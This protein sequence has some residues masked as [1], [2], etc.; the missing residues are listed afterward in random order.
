MSRNGFRKSFRNTLQ[1]FLA[2]SAKLN[3]S[4]V[5]ETKSVQALVNSVAKLNK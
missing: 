4:A 2:L 5:I 1:K 3:Y